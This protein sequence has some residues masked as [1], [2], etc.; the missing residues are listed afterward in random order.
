MKE[1]F[2][3]CIGYLGSIHI[4]NRPEDDSSQDDVY[5]ASSLGL[6]T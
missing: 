6:T 1:I 4:G 2:V 3:E 5:G